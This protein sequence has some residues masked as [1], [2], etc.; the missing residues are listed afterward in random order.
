M[1]S[2]VMGKEALVTDQ[3]LLFGKIAVRLKFCTAGEVEKGFALQ[4]QSPDRLPLGQILVGEGLITPEQHSEILTIQRRNTSDIEPVQEASKESIFL[5]K[6]AVRERLMTEQNV[7]SCLRIQALEAERRS[8]GTIMV[9]QGYLSPKQLNVLLALQQKKIMSCPK[10][11]LSFTVL[12]ISGGKNVPCPRCRGTLEDG[13]PTAS[14]RTD[15]MLNTGVVRMIRQA[16]P[17]PPPEI[18][19]RTGSSVRMVKMICPICSKPFQEPV[20]TKGQVDC[21]NCYS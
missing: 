16:D 18:R 14:L 15:A 3:D 20:D 21:P 12:T 5:G 10:C 1:E 11:R 8:L 6:L 7:N 4:A 2:K 9:E 17:Q 19:R 13:K